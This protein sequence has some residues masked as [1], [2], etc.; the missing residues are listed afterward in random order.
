M[1]IHLL[2]EGLT[3]EVVVAKLLPFCGHELGW[4]YGKKGCNYIQKKATA[5]MY[6]A[7]EKE[8]LLVLT[9]LCDTGAQCAQVALQRY[10]FNKCPHPPRTFLCQFSVNEIE[11]WLL[12]DREGLASFIGVAVSKIPLHP[13]SEARPKETLVGLARKSSMKVFREEFAPSPGHMSFVGPKYSSLLHEFI[14][15]HWDIENAIQ[16]APSLERCVRRLGEIDT[17]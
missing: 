6:L 1:I 3:E 12:A 4:V 10:I 13:E 7:K 5:F 15:C 16:N 8:G 14:R 17:Y 2:A 9:D 11:S